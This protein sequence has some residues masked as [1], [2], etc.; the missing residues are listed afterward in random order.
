MGTK[1][2]SAARK[3]LRIN[4]TVEEKTAIVRKI[5]DSLRADPKKPLTA[6]G[7]ELGIWETVLRSWLNHYGEPYGWTG[8]MRTFISSIR[9]NPTPSAAPSPEPSDAAPPKMA[10]PASAWAEKF[11]SELLEAMGVEPEGQ[12]TDASSQQ[13]LV[14]SGEPPRR[15]PGRPTDAERAL[16]KEREAAERELARSGHGLSRYEPRRVTVT[17]PE[18]SERQPELPFRAGPVQR[19]PE[20][21]PPQQSGFMDKVTAEALRERDAV[22]TTLKILMRDGGLPGPR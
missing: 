11:G 22:L 20:P 9:Q 8:N 4:R 18:E 19:E 3:K 12:S 21:A 7:D 10:P 13:T 6:I 2:T 15:K 14:S 16:R 5:L 1:R 17:P